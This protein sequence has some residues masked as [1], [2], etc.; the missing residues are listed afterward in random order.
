ME[1]TNIQQL[2]ERIARLEKIFTPQSDVVYKDL[3]GDKK[4]MSIQSVVRMKGVRLLFPNLGAE[5]LQ[6]DEAASTLVL[7]PRDK[8][9]LDEVHKAYVAA[10]EAGIYSGKIPRHVSLEQLQKN[11][12]ESVFLSTNE[13]IQ[14][15][16][17]N[18]RDFLRDTIGED[19]V[20]RNVKVGRDTHGEKNFVLL[21][22]E[23]QR[24][25]HDEPLFTGDEGE[26]VIN[27]FAYEY[28]GRY[29][30]TRYLQGFRRTSKRPSGA[31]LFF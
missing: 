17:E 7:I 6:S 26:I 28:R 11:D 5:N 24:M 8:E 31:S 4:A 18:I 21:G 3:L 25:S 16:K 15:N 2:E 14:K 30:I 20:M 12:Q 19:I 27:F 9:I 22:E 13:F 23:G 1:T 10:Y 29:G